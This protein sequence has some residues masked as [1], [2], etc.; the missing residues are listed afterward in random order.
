MNLVIEY[1]KDEKD[2]YIKQTKMVFS[3]QYVLSPFLTNSTVKCFSGKLCWNSESCCAQ[4]RLKLFLIAFDFYLSFWMFGYSWVLF[5]IEWGSL[6]RFNELIYWRKWHVPPVYHHSHEP[7]N[8]TL[9][10][11]Y[12]LYW[13]D[14]DHDVGEG[15]W[16]VEKSK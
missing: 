12:G 9:D 4:R 2:D 5:Y 1:K 15:I 3:R 6:E 16:T 13:G 10:K 14:I 8:W 7:W 11:V